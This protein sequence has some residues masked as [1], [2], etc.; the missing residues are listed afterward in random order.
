[1]RKSNWLLALIPLAFAA[2]PAQ[3]QSVTCGQPAQNGTDTGNANLA[4]ATPCFTGANAAGYTIQ[5]ISIPNSLAVGNLSVAIYSDTGS[6]ATPVAPGTLLCKSAVVPA[7]A[8][9][10]A[11]APV[12]CPVLAP[13][14][15]YWIAKNTDMNAQ[16]E[17][18]QSGNCPA[19]GTSQYVTAANGTWPS[20]FGTP[21]ISSRCHSVF[22]TLIPAA[23]P[24]PTKTVASIG[25]RFSYV[26]AAGVVHAIDVNQGPNTF[27]LS[28]IV[29]Y[30][31]GSQTVTPFNT[32]A[33]TVTPTK[34]P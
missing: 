6:A 33:V 26:D 15:I 2:I 25:V 11:I 24:V 4:I 29:N 22:V 13:N 34:A 17:G 1:M 8:G 19:G 23:P 5:G 30:S 3:G 10:P 16:T 32:S 21:K 27:T 18:V 12:N 14:A 20:N 7:T 9:T 28:L 31:D